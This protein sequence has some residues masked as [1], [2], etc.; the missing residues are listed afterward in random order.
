MNDK[1]SQSNRLLSAGGAL[2]AITTLIILWIFPI[3]THHFEL[4]ITDL[5]FNLRSYMER[6]PDMN[7]D[8]VLIALDDQSKLAS[9]FEYLW[10]YYLYAETVKKIT[11]GD[12]T[13][14]GMDIIFS[15]TVDTSGWSLLINELANSY[16]AINPYMTIFGDVKN[17]LEISAHRSILNELMLEKLPIINQGDVHHVEDITYT[18]NS[19]LQEVSSGLGFV[20]IETDQDGVLRRLPIIAELNEQEPFLAPR[21]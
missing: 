15:G 7:S 18:T 6:E 20:N 8:I 1:K 2:T 5:K 13:S 16:M 3:L 12:P 19:N 14:F 9:G 10:P 21:S 17:P 11:D 4:K